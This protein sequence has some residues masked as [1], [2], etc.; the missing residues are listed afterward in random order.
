MKKKEFMAFYLLNGYN[1]YKSLDLYLLL[2]FPL[3]AQNSLFY[4]FVIAK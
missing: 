1:K 4:I 3:K 2:I